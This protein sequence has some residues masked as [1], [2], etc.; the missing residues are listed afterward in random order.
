MVIVRLG[1]QFWE[2]EPT[3]MSGR[4]SGQTKVSQEPGPVGQEQAQGGEGKP[5][6][7]GHDPTAQS[8]KSP[9]RDYSDVN[10]TTLRTDLRNRQLSIQGISQDLISS[11]GKLDEDKKLAAATAHSSS[12][13]MYNLGVGPSFSYV[14]TSDRPKN[15]KLLWR[16]CKM[17]AS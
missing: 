1:L 2:M 15:N 10:V 5:L 4:T 13:V 11:L 9:V 7:S 17:L 14:S 8:S 3:K 12:I 6:S 16:P